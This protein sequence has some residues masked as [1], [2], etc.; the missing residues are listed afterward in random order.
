[1][2]AKCSQ[3]WRG[4][5]LAAQ[6]LALIIMAIPGSYVWCDAENTFYSA[7]YLRPD[8]YVFPWI[9]LIYG[10][11]GLLMLFSFIAWVRR[12]SGLFILLITIV[13]GGVSSGS[14]S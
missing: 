11:A 3:T 12:K 4:V 1:M 6:V 13:C 5:S 14:S 9:W 8:P 2:A 7:S 10:F